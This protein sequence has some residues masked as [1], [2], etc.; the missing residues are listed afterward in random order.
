[1]AACHSLQ[2]NTPLEL[3]GCST[4][5]FVFVIEKKKVKSPEHKGIWYMG[6]K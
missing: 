4:Q 1:M 5:G 2:L 6:E 3:E